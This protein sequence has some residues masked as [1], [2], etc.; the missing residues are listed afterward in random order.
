MFFDEKHK[1]IENK[2]K[3]STTKIGGHAVHQKKR[4]EKSKITN[5]ILPSSLQISKMY[6]FPWEGDDT[7]AQKEY[8]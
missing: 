4:K 7:K 1:F 8:E 5:G 3:K 2:R 6:E